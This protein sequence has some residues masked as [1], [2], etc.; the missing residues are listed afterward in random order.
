MGAAE[1]GV[2]AL[3]E[4]A[5]DGGDG[6][7]VGAGGAEEDGADGGAVVEVEGGVLG[8]EV[9][10]VVGGGEGAVD[11]FGESGAAE[12]LEGDGDLEGVGAAGGAEG[13]AEEVGESGFGVVVGVEVGGVVVE[14]V[15]WWRSGTARRPADAGCQPSLCRSR[16]TLWARSRP[17]RR[18][19]WVGLKRE[20]PP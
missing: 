10:E 2:A 4:G 11:E 6:V 19:R 8:D 16:V 7:V 1:D 13:A 12:C 17:W 18:V 5:A 14:G 9:G 15:R 3:E 20:G